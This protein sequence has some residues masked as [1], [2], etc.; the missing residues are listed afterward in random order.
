MHA[1]DTG[2]VAA[3]ANPERLQRVLFNL[4]QNA[5]RHTPP[6]GSITVRAASVDGAV[7]VEVRDTGSGIPA[8]D[9]DKVFEP[10]YRGDRARTD[11]GAGL[12]LAICSAIV[13]AHGGRIWLGDAP[14][15]TAVCFSLPVAA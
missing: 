1:D 12:G 7:R 5:I 10:F 4:I 6:D 8:A 13:E 2:P 9:R 15:G 11:A 3:H 14:D